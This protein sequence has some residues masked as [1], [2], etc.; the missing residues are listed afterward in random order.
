M[1]IKLEGKMSVFGGPHDTGVTKSEGLALFDHNDVQHYPELFL[2][3][4]PHGTTGVA[5]RLNPDA[6]YLACRWDYSVTSRNHLRSIKVKVTNPKTGES[7]MAQ[8]CD[9]GPNH[10]TGRIA[11]LS[12]GLAKALDL[13]TNDI[14]RVEID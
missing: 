3:E 13:D 7:L 10:N 8:P 9:W 1:S 2:K 4:Q 12:P 14:C 11:D 5:R 6:Y